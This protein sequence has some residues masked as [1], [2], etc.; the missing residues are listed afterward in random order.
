MDN[1]I[2]LLNPPNP[3]KA[4]IN[5]D[6]MGGMG[7]KVS[8]SKHSIKNRLLSRIKS[9]L[10]RIPVMQLVMAAT[11]LKNNHLPVQVID[12]ANTKLSLEET[13]DN[14]KK[15]N[16]KIIVMAVS[17]SCILYERDVVAKKIKNALPDSKIIVI[18]DTVAENPSLLVKPFDIAV[19]GEVEKCIL[20]LCNNKSL[21]KIKNI[22]YRENNKLI[23]REKSFL[24]AEELNKLPAP[25]W[26][27][28]PYKEYRYYPLLP[29]SPI[30]SILASRGCPYACSYCP[31]SKNQGRKW[32]ARSVESVYSELKKDVK[33]YGFKSIF[34][35]DPLFTLDKKR[36]YKLCNMIKKDN[37]KVNFVFETRPELLDNNLLKKLYE[38]GCKA[39]NLGIEDIHPEV[40]TK[41]N[42]KVVNKSLIISIVRSAEKIGIKISCFFILGLPGSTKKTTDETISFSINLMPSLVEYKIA[43][44]FPGTDLY[45]LAK[46]EKWI[47]NESYELLG[48]YSSVMQISDDLSPKFLKSKMKEAFNKFY[49]NPRYLIREFFRGAIFKNIYY[50]L[51]VFLK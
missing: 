18:G 2:L 29:T 4:Y 24:S 23:K 27:L 1:L 51:K 31:Y 45:Y 10:I 26:E 11:I 44:P 47:K 48:G 5:R 46:K 34:F 36:I 49:Y 14:I 41:V 15:L 33:Y 6:L 19:I 17:S 40:L 25:S 37:L 50:V 13:L 12:A 16:P 3:D 38:A 9:S 35:R 43:T 7:V 20:D 22:A 42:R 21:S 32:R 8:L 30:A 39:I 28:F